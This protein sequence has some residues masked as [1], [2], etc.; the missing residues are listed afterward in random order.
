MNA[1]KS[2]F[3]VDVPP[4]NVVYS[5]LNN[6]VNN[7]GTFVTVTLVEVAENDKV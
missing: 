6:V 5:L 1:W 2:S 3:K 7:D 4:S